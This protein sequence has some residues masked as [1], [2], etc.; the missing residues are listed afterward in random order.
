M[1]KK[2]INILVVSD[3][4]HNLRNLSLNSLIQSISNTIQVIDHQLI[5]TISLQHGQNNQLGSGMIKV[6]DFLTQSK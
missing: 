2:L 6:I 4:E 5:D 3:H 1:F